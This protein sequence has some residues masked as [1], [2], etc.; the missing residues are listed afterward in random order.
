[1]EELE[2][3]LK[4]Y[5]LNHFN[6]KVLAHFED[7]DMVWAVQ[8]VIDSKDQM[9]IKVLLSSRTPAPR[10]GAIRVPRRKGES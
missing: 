6:Q 2:D 5:L 10:W 7:K 3:G 1:M 4:G 9:K 8:N